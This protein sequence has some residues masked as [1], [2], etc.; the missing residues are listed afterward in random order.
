LHARVVHEDVERAHPL[1]DIRCPGGHRGTVGHVEHGR[2]DPVAGQFGGGFGEAFTVAPVEDHRAAG[3]REATGEREPDAP[4]G[5]GDQGRPAADVEEGMSRHRRTTP[6][7][8][9]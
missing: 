9:S 4:T 8:N 3:L 2:A 5:A 1:L 7:R 6:V